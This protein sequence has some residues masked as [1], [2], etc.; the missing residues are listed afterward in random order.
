[1]ARLVDW[2]AT[3]GKSAAT[4]GI[5]FALACLTRYEAWPVTAA[6][7]PLA[8]WARWR[9]GRSVRDSLRDVAPIALPPLL[10]ALSFMT[11]SR[12]VVGQW[13]V[14]SGFF[15]PD[16]KFATPLRAATA[17]WQGVL[18]LSGPVLVGVAAAG[19][20]AMTLIAVLDR[21]RAD[22]LVALSLAASAALPW[23]AFMR[24]HPY[25][26]RY[27][28]PLVA[29]QAIGV[30]VVAGLLKRAAPAAAAAVLVLSLVELGPFSP[31]A[32]MVV[33]AQLDRPHAAG[34]R[35]VSACLGAVYHGETVMASM[36][37]LGH[38]MQEL[39]SSGFELRDFL[40]EGNGDIWLAALDAPRPYAGWILMEEEAEGGDLLAHA[41]RQQP[42]WLDGF[43]RRCEGGGVALYERVPEPDPGPAPVPLSRASAP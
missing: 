20:I 8:A 9:A 4:V 19:L 1:V 31:T 13:F 28:V 12:I 39:A 5:I 14:S 21:R 2:L 27:M 23:L 18:G 24:G 30:G 6:A 17:I 10:T 29:A 16:P 41:A 7:V 3:R 15:V 26:V 34:R 33:E 22:V 36:S 25:R 32:P 42:G 38:Y 40:H 37:S 43:L 35:S 11:F